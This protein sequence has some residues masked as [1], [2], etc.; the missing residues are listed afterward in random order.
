MPISGGDVW[1]LQA[2]S[3]GDDGQRLWRFVGGVESGCV[4]VG[5]MNGKKQAHNVT[6]GVV[7]VCS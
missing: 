1:R 3:A 7:K 2:E 6:K 4:I 5:T